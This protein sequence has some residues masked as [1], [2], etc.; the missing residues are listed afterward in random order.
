MEIL[1]KIEDL[2]KSFNNNKILKG[3]ELEVQKG[4]VHA[5]LGANGAGKSTL[6]K[7]IG[8]ILERNKGQIYLN[9]KDIVCHSPLEARSK[10]I[11]IIHQELSII[12]QLTALENF[13]LGREITSN[14]ILSQ[15]AMIKEY[16]EVDKILNFNIPWNEKLGNLSVANHQMIEIMKVV[17]LDTELIIMDEPTTSLTENEKQN[18][19]KIISKLKE[20]NKTVIYISHM[21]EEI[22]AI[23]D[24]ISVLYEGQNIGTFPV[25][26]M[27]QIKIAKLMSGKNYQVTKKVKSNAYINLKPILDIKNMSLDHKLYNINFCLYPGEILGIAGLVGS[28]RSEIVQ[29]IYGIEKYTGQ[30]YLNDNLV[31]ILSPSD[32][33]KN[34]IGLIP[35]NRKS[36]GLSL[37]Q[38]IY[39]NSTILSLDRLKT[40]GILNLHK[41]YKYTNDAVK[42]LSIK[43]EDI[44]SPVKNLSGGNQQKIVISKWFSQDLKILIF[45]E[46]TKGIDI[47]AKEDIFKTIEKFTQKGI[48]VIFISSDLEEVLRI[49]DRIMTIHN[50]KIITIKENTNLTTK[51]IMH[52]IFVTNQ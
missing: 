34:G 42:E 16:M 38:P 23:C 43:V 36:Q 30:I 5:L 15:Q 28:G 17:A 39:Q 1:L 29:S 8:G 33:I 12:P 46:P 50:G 18:L 24:N 22:F 20:R 13:F 40:Y 44:N 37:R 9:N 52:D 48:A 11:S 49:S 2:H 27:T 31:S 7:I 32:A 10:G 26:E 4:T 19:F 41:E 51:D 47:N 45:D 6:I 3:I 35:E 25:S 14:G 21:L